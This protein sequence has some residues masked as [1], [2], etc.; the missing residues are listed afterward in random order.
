MIIIADTSCLILYQHIGRLDILQK[1]FPELYITEEVAVE[2]GD[3][4][5]W[6][7]IVKV[8]KDDTYR[9]LARSLGLGETSS[10]ALALESKDSLLIIDE[11]KGR[12]IAQSLEIEI[13][14]SLGLLI[15]AKQKGIIT[16]VNDIL[17]QIDQTNFRVSDK[18]RAAIL[19]IA[20]ELK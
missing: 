2:F 10:I 5:E 12:K 20:G 14:G 7:T 19:E 13:I 9:E 3:I 8:K 1:L 11:K 4:P 16:S 17:L 6:I 18:V 15:K